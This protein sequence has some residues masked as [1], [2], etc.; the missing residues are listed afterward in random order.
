MP[1]P[2][3]FR[4]STAGCEPGVAPGG[5]QR[6]DQAVLAHVLARDALGGQALREPAW[7]WAPAARATISVTSGSATE[8]LKCSRLGESTGDCDQIRPMGETPA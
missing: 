8:W 2:E 4:I 1:P 7:T 6:A 3:P 5:R